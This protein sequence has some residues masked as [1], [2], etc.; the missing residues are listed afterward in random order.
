M[1]KNILFIDSKC[2]ICQKSTKLLYRLDKKGVLYFA[3]LDGQS[4]KTLEIRSNIDS[5]VLY[6]QGEIYI[7]STA[8]IEAISLLGGIYRSIV[9]AYVI[10][11]K[12]RDMV[13]DYV[14]KH[15]Y[16]FKKSTS[17]MLLTED[18]KS[19]VLD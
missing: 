3:P 13:Y 6:K 10:P 8:V 4:A 17:C 5:V 12:L 18:E 16:F 9:L 19:R 7:K 11:L 14:A 15:R 1:Y 2:A